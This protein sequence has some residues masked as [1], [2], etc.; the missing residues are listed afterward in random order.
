M[1]E[2]NEDLLPLV[3]LVRRGQGYAPVNLSLGRAGTL[4]VLPGAPF[5]VAPSVA[6][7]LLK[8]HPNQV[9]RVAYTFEDDPATVKVETASK[10]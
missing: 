7:R 9:V 10:E 2:V 3:Y 8:N 1:S 4:Q 5:E 6:K